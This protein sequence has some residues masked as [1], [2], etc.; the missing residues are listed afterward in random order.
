M[1]SALVTMSEGNSAYNLYLEVNDVKIYFSTP[2]ELNNQLLHIPVV[3]TITFSTCATFV[4]ADHFNY[5]LMKFKP[6]S[7][8]I[9]AVWSI[10]WNEVQS[11]LMKSVTHLCINE[12]HPYTDFDADDNDDVEIV[13]KIQKMSKMDH[14]ENHKNALM[15]LL[16][17]SNVTHLYYLGHSNFDDSGYREVMFDIVKV[18]VNPCLKCIEINN[19]SMH[20][21]SDLLLK[22]MGQ[23][24]DELLL[25]EQA[26]YQIHKRVLNGDLLFTIDDKIVTT[27]DF[28]EAIQNC[29]EENWRELNHPLWNWRRRKNFMCTLTSAGF[30]SDSMN[31]NMHASHCSNVLSCTDIVR[32]IV[33]FI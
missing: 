10:N 21:I 18:L 11:E 26:F 7:I 32:A 16:G 8:N 31:A 22:E 25:D 14:E 33:A 20:I 12:D 27:S 4:R 15:E 5:L 3:D 1:A 29:F 9:E 17:K 30:L 23:D 13:S 28:D 6:T 24:E 2:F 19:T